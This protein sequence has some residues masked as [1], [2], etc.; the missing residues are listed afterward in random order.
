MSQHLLVAGAPHARD[1][2]AGDRPIQNAARAPAMIVVPPR[3]ESFDSDVTMIDAAVSSSAATPH[4][5]RATRRQPLSSPTPAAARDH[6][7]LEIVNQTVDQQV[8][9]DVV[10]DAL[11]S[12]LMRSYRRRQSAAEERPR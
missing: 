9:L 6:G 7:L 12:L 2:S 4:G 5:A 10:Y 8:N 1:E 3:S 11:A